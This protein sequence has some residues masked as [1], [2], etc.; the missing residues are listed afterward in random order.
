MQ[1]GQHPVIRTSQQTCVLQSL[2]NADSS[3][4]AILEKC[5]QTN[6]RVP[7]TQ[8]AI[9]A[10]VHNKVLMLDN[11]TANLLTKARGGSNHKKAASHLLPRSKRLQ[12]LP[13][14]CT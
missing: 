14:T 2:Q 9:A 1:A 3:V 4:N 5:I 11:P 8:A 10:R 13:G 6:A 12:I 7:D